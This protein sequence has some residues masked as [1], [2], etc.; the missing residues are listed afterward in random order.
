MEGEPKNHQNHREVSRED[1]LERARRKS[2]EFLSILLEHERS[3]FSPEDPQA[4]EQLIN[5]LLSIKNKDLMEQ[6]MNEPGEE[7]LKEAVEI[8]RALPKE[9]TEEMKTLSLSGLI[10]KYRLD[11]FGLSKDR[12]AVEIVLALSR[13]LSTQSE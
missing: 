9:V 6:I 13:A 2:P 7:K 12:S 4:Y 8:F 10:K 1:A 3:G 5:N 11:Q